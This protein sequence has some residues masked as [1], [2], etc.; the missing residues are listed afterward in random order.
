MNCPVNTLNCNACGSPLTL[1]KSFSGVYEGADGKEYD[2]E[3]SLRC[4]KDGCGR[5]YPIGCIRN[6]NDFIFPK[7]FIQTRFQLEKL[8]QANGI[9]D[10]QLRNITDLF[11]CHGINAKEVEGYTGLH[12][13]QKRIFE[14][15]IVNYFN[16]HGMEARATIIPKQISHEKTF[17]RFAYEFDGRNTWLH[18]IDGGETWY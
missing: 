18:V 1:S 4:E 8:Y 13:I 2:W 6:E 11:K 10:Y 7:K 9:P 12:D 17:L 14:K 5:I 15:F 16:R 3:V